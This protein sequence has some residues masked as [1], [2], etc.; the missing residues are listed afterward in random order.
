MNLPILVSSVGR[1]SQLI[2]NMRRS[3]TSLNLSGSIIGV[4]CSRAAPAAY[5]VDRFIQVPRCNDP[6]F[7]PS[8]LTICKEN[9]VALL[10]PTI[11]TE[12]G[13]YAAHREDF[14]ARGTHVVIS[15]PET[16]DI[17]L[18]KKATNCWLLQNGFP[19]VRQGTPI[20]VLTQR[21]P[22]WQF[23]VIAKP[24]CGSASIGVRV[25]NSRDSLS[26][27]IE[28][29]NDLV[30]EELARGG[31]YTVNVLMNRHARCVCAVPHLRLEVRAGEVSKGITVKHKGMMELVSRVA[32]RLPEA[33]G[34]LNVQGFLDSEGDFRIT[35]INPRFGGGYPL[36][37][38]AGADFPR[39]LI[40]EL[41]GLPST[42]SFDAWRDGLA[43][44][45][46][47]SAVFLPSVDL[48][49]HRQ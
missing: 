40:E 43:M 11:D 42:S 41:L 29:R 7:V 6:D 15:A 24:R 38:Q 44:L 17:C 28:E 35:E 32:E 2:D 22:D 21:A 13:L 8:L 26:S 18:D 37:H 49:N 31:E 25:V 36:A 48:E 10:F 30:V 33:Y 16:I 27:L 19:T 12:L 34:P 20:Q 47:D 45:R 4:D 14:A 1:R 9:K 39:W 5:L 46:Y 23:P 3:L